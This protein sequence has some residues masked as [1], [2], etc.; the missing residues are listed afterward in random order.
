MLC[1]RVSA[2][3]PAQ[4][5]ALEFKIRSTPHT[6]I[7]MPLS[8]KVCFSSVGLYFCGSTVGG[9]LK[10]HGPPDTGLAKSPQI[11]ICHT[12]LLAAKWWAT[13]LL[14]VQKFCHS[15]YML[16]AGFWTQP[17]MMRQVPACIVYMH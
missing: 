11:L 17:L 15:P 2:L 13:A 10:Q 14:S 16:R 6:Q 1:Y 4:G 7:W 3:A 12:R 5:H 8:L 9:T